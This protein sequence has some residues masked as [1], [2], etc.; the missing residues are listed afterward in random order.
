MVKNFKGIVKIS[1]VK[2]EFEEL[3]DTLNM[4]VDEYNNMEELKDIDYNKAGSTLSQLGY[5]L[6]IGGLKQFMQIY[7]GYC[8]GCRVFK[9][10]TNQCK[11]TGGILVTSNKLYRIPTDLVSGYGTMLFYNPTTN[12]CQVGGTTTITKTITLPVLTSNS[13]YG[14]M[15]ASINSGSAYKATVRSNEWS[16]GGWNWGNWTSQTGN[17]KNWLEGKDFNSLRRLKWTFPQKM[18]FKK[19]TKL[20]FS[21]VAVRYQQIDAI[22]AWAMQCQGLGNDITY[23]AG[24][25]V[26]TSL[27]FT[28]TINNNITTSSF[29]IGL[30]LLLL[31]SGVGWNF[32]IQNLRFS[33]NP[34]STTVVTDDDNHDDLY[35]IADLNWVKTS[36]DKLW[37]NDLPHSMY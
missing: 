8:F 22:I 26:G 23:S 27:P 32:H 13:S 25:R 7:D 35:K 20:T 19:G 36:S 28:I 31:V 34:T 15:S 3:V 10:A 6:T 21:L 37:L 12:K 4:S 33:S 18:T 16:A 24:S 1:E 14:T 17:F 11:P 29:E 9:T 2:N 5:T 30:G